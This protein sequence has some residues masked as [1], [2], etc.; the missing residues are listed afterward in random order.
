MQTVIKRAFW[1]ALMLTCSAPAYGLPREAVEQVKRVTALVEV[2]IGKD[3]GFGTAFC[4]DAKGVFV[5]NAH[6]VGKLHKMTVILCPGEADQRIVDAK[7]LKV[8]VE[9]DLALIQIDDP[10]TLKALELGDAGTLFDTMDLTAFGYPFG[11]AL[12]SSEKEYP[13]ISVSTGH[14]TS[15]RK[16][17]GELE[18]IQLDAV[19][20]PGNSGGP[21]LDGNGRVVGIVQAGLPGAGINF[22]I[23]VSRLQ[24]FLKLPMETIPED[25]ISSEPPTTGTPSH[26]NTPDPDADPFHG[27]QWEL[28]SYL[29]GTAP[30]IREKLNGEVER[31]IIKIRQTEAEIKKFT[32]AAIVDEQD[33]I[34]KVRQSAAYKQILAE[35]N[36]AEQDLEAARKAG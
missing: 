32:H 12:A 36:K 5:T 10:G 20:N 9:M 24:K 23:P 4:I 15:L 2:H 21:V 34:E 28:T 7:V 35:K 6:V 14:I 16:K 11:N 31:L 19:L 30:Q 27:K 3:R 29:K 1:L 22:A 17:A 33:A 26:R 8:N 25:P 13:S 18:L